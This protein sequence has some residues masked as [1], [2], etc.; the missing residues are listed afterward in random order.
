[1][2][3]WYSDRLHSSTCLCVLCIYKQE[4]NDILMFNTVEIKC[5]TFWAAAVLVLSAIFCGIHQLSP[6]VGE[7]VL[8]L[9]RLFLKA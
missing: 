8:K 4:G 2:W 7:W 9:L 5:F 1:M 6:S 3:Q